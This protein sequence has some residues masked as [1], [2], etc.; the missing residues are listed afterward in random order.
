MKREILQDWE[1][2]ASNAVF[3][4]KRLWN[5]VEG[6]VDMVEIFRQSFAK[7]L[8]EKFSSKKILIN[9]LPWNTF[10]HFK[11]FEFS[12]LQHFLQQKIQA[13]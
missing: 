8:D 6:I 4:T 1:N 12:H 5:E 10:F 3:T 11:S 9:Y 13:T 7:W 2:K